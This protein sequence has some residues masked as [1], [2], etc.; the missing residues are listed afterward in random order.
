VCL[1]KKLWLDLLPEG[2]GHGSGRIHSL[3]AAFSTISHNEQKDKQTPHLDP[4]SVCQQKNKC[5]PSWK[6][7]IINL[8]VFLL[9]ESY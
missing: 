8:K 7:E 6:Q 4:Q 3:Q 9:I 1:G 5:Q 2:S